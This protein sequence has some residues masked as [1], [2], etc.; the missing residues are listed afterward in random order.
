MRPAPFLVLLLSAVL[1][2]QELQIL[3]EQILQERLETVPQT[4]AG[5][6]TRLIS[7][8]HGVGCETREQAVPHSKAPNLI[9]ILPGEI[10]STIVTGGHFDFVSVGT[11][12]IDDWSGAAMLPSLYQSLKSQPRHHRYVFIAFAAEEDGLYGSREFVKELSPE[13]R[14]ALH[15]M[16]N[17]ECLGTTP[18]K[19]WA[20]R[21]DKQ[22]LSIYRRAAHGLKLEPEVFNVDDIGDDDSH[23]FLRA[24]IP[25]LT[26]HSTTRETLNLIH[27][28]RDTVQAIHPGD[29]YDAYRLS[30]TFLALLDSEVQ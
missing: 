12:A 6:Q 8:F 23:P 28:P 7:L 1:R 21:A 22:L 11:G 17:L 29:Y 26:I 27:S 2:P 16:L 19:V 5:R 25:V 14:V 9:C 20:S 4:L 13:E 24:K 18:P 30:A 3:P 15:A 10:E